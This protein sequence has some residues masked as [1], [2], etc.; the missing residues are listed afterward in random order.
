VAAPPVD[1]G[2]GTGL[3]PA[4]AAAFAALR[5]RFLSGLPARWTEISTAPN[6][7]ACSAALHRL[8]GAAASFGF[9]GLGA[10]A[11]QAEQA[12]AAQREPLLRELERQVRTALDTVP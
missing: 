3:P 4:A 10:L 1:E 9:A 7:A 6:E 12:P 5:A 11:R 8:A 2:S